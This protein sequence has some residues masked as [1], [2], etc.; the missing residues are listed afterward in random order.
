MG[1]SELGLTL[2]T[3]FQ[4]FLHILTVYFD[5][6]WT[7]TGIKACRIKCVSGCNGVAILLCFSI[8]LHDDTDLGLLGLHADEGSTSSMFK[9]LFDALPGESGAFIERVR[10]NP[11]RHCLTLHVKYVA[12]RKGNRIETSGKYKVSLISTIE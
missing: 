3:N 6:K 4:R 8:I 5:T 11:L 2:R 9:Y 10:P 12:N 7:G 1:K